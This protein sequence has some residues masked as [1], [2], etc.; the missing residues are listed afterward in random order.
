VAVVLYADDITILVT[1]PDDIEV[2]NEIIQ[3]YERP[4][5]ALLNARTSQALAVGIWE[6]TRSVLGIPYSEVITIL[7]FQ[8]TNKTEALRRASWS[9]VTARVKLKGS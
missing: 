7:G 2:L 8:M 5:R 4:T 9:R 3:C 1:A 6:P